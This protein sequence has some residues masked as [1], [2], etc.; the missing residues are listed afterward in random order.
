MTPPIVVH[1]P[2][3]GG[4]RRVTAH[5]EQLG[6]AFRAEDVSEFL[7]HAGLS[8]DEIQLDDPNLIEWRGGGPDVWDRPQ[9]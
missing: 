1:P 4:G 3:D 2:A 6:V 8:E 5:A 7:R 9:P